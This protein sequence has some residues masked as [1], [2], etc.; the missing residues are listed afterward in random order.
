MG[1]LV[2]SEATH[3]RLLDIQRRTLGEDHPGI[4][5]NMS[6]LAVVLYHRGSYAE[7][8]ELL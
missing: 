5:D 7:S 2:A 6:D 3:R 4:L 1:E 8:E